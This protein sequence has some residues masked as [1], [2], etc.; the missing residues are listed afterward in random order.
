MGWTILIASDGTSFVFKVEFFAIL[1][2]RLIVDEM[3]EATVANFNIKVAVKLFDDVV[4]LPVEFQ[5]SVRLLL[6]EKGFLFRGNLSGVFELFSERLVSE[7]VVKPFNVGED[8]RFSAVLRNFD[9]IFHDFEISEFF[10]VGFVCEELVVDGVELEL[11][12]LR[13]AG[14]REVVV[15]KLI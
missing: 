12:P 1:I 4:L 5:V 6:E 7:E 10:G 9:L 14:V 8:H 13:A 2:W 3:G 15:R 11:V